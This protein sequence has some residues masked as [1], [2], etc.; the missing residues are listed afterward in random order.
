MQL[1][2]EVVFNQVI[3]PTSVLELLKDSVDIRTVI[4]NQIQ[5]FLLH[6]VFLSRQKFLLIVRIFSVNVL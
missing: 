4:I 1:F 5:S 6:H 3:L 2:N